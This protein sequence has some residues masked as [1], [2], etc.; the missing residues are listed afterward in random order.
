MEVKM[1][2]WLKSKSIH[3]ESYNDEGLVTN[4]DHYKKFTEDLLET[5]KFFEPHIIPDVNTIIN[6]G[7][8]NHKLCMQMKIDEKS[9][10]KFVYLN[11][12]KK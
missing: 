11:S 5:V 1:N 2:K 6:P 8:E 10:L 3:C 4:N 7:T 9:L 12:Y